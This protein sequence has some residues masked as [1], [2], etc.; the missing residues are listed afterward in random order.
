MYWLYEWDILVQ[1]YTQHS[2]FPSHNI[3]QRHPY[4][5]QNRKYTKQNTN[6]VP[7]WIK[8]L[9]KKHGFSWVQ[10][11]PRYSSNMIRALCLFER[12]RTSMDEKVRVIL[13]GNFVSLCNR[14]VE[15]DRDCAPPTGGEKKN[16]YIPTNNTSSTTHRIMLKINDTKK[17][18]TTQSICS[19]YKFPQQPL[20]H[21]QTKWSC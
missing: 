8:L 18:S 3:P 4:W 5:I 10:Y 20:L 15:P 21:G 11:I 14:T 12:Q 19:T 7:E 13:A 2:I 17:N 1:A 6:C 9:Q 16:N